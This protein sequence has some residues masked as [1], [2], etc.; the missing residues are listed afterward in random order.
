MKNNVLKGIA[1]A[2]G[3]SIAT[4]YRYE[5][6]VENIIDESI[7]NV[8]EALN[9]L[10]ESIQKSKKELKKIFDLAVTKMGE[11]RAGIFEAQMMILE[12]PVLLDNIKERIKKERRAPI[13]IVD[14]EF[15][16]YQ[17]ILAQSQETYLKERGHDIDDIKNRIIRNLKKKKWK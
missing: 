3:I 14:D 6:E 2:P 7:D 13:F 9:N 11:K 4:A 8:E 16:K 1:A 5:K 12:D 10:D 17:K 15:S